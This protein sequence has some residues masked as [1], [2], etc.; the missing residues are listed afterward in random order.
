MKNILILLILVTTTCFSQ[1]HVVGQHKKFK[2]TIYNIL[3]IPTT[4]NQSEEIAYF[5]AYLLPI[6][7]KANLQTALDTYGVVRLESG[8]Y[9]GVNIVMNSNQKLYGNPSLTRVSNITIT[10]GSSNVVLQD[11]YPVS[12]TITLQAGGVISNCT[13]KS[14][15]FATLAATNAQIENNTFINFGGVINFNCSTSGYFRNN[16]IIKHQAQTNVLNLVMKGNSTT[17]SYGN[18]HLWS[19]FLT[20][21]GNTTD[22]NNIQSATF[23]GID[24]EGWNLNGLGSNAMF[25]AKNMGNVK[26]TDFGG[27]N[28]YSGLRTPAFDIDADNLFIFQK[29]I[30][31]FA[32]INILSPKTNLFALDY[33]ED[34]YVRS[35]G[36]VTGFEAVGDYNKDSKFTY[37]T[38]EQTSTITDPTIISKLTNTILDTQY[39]PWARPTWETLPDPLGANWRTERVGKPDS[40]AYIQN[41]IN[42]N[43]IAELPEGIFYISSTL[44]LPIDNAAIASKGIQGKGTG[45]TVICGLTDDF[46]LITPLN[47]INLSRFTLANLTLQGGSTGIYYSQDYG[48]QFISYQNMKFVVFR[49]QTYGMH[50]KQINGF[51]NCFLENIAF[52]N[53][54]IGLYQDPLVPYVDLDTSS[55]IDKTMFYQSQFINCNTAFSMLSTRSNNLN[56]WVDCKFDGGQV[57]LKANGFSYVIANCDF[58]N[59]VGDNVI[60][61]SASL[62]NSNFYNNT[63]AVSTLRSQTSRIEGCNFLDNANLLTKVQSNPTRTYIANSTVTGSILVDIPT[64]AFGPYTGFFV[65]NNLIANPTLSKLFTHIKEN[66]PTVVIDAAP[67]PYPQLLVTQ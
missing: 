28:S 30:Q 36:T 20:P 33:R 15:K 40:T 63:S 19:N 5:N 58:T 8:D 52:V 21:H 61:S 27:T 35:T 17:P 14:I 62:Y 4:A 57:A 11:L 22:L 16:K 51:D 6:S 65:N 23:V 66:V 53:C 34:G 31:S 10:A 18:V 25:Y 26:I 12:S 54:N 45:K 50:L 49:D 56:S 46:P 55:Y 1:K 38:V 42:T 39:T 32:S 41:L 2:R 48:K 60:Y 9:S 64:A 29:H 59:I 7:Q 13:F 47:N 3:N 43:G 37:D 44:L 24:A 67:N